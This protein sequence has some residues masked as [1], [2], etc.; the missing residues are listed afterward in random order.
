MGHRTGHDVYPNTVRGDAWDL[1]SFEP[2]TSQLIVQTENLEGNGNA[3]V[4]AD[5]T[6]ID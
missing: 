3:V 2:K 4:V 6:C 1:V 5:I